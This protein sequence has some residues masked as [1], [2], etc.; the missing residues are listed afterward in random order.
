MLA[1][2]LIYCLGS[3]RLDEFSFGSWMRSIINI[4]QMLKVQV[5][6]YLCCTDITVPQ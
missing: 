1:G 2:F 4:G 3:S 6:V 5:S